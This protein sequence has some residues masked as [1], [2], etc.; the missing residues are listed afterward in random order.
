MKIHYFQHVA[1]EDIGSI[2]EWAKQNNARL[3]A[4]RF[5]ANEN[6][7]I[8]D[9]IDLLIVMGGPMNIYEEDKY[10]WLVAEK[11]FI[12]QALT[13][14]KST[15]GICLGSQLIADALGAHIY[16]NGEKEIGW[17]PVKRSP[18]ASATPLGRIFPHQ[19]DFFHWHGDT[20]DIPPDASLLASSEGCAYQAFQSGEWVLGL[21]F[22]PEATPQTV[23]ALIRNNPDELVAGRWIENADRM[24]ADS[25]RFENSRTILYEIL[26]YFM[27]L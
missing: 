12:R 21:Q 19:M 2:R 8:L 6:L 9:D 17:F 4:T 23:S 16:P 27:Q 5:F 7:P 20:F 11:A 10:P 15:F 22:H 14:G 25:S 13:S 3:T 18:D 1:Y 24:L 26:D